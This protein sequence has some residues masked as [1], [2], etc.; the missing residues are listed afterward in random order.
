[1]SAVYLPRPAWTDTARGGALLTDT[2]LVGNAIHYPGRLADYG[3]LTQAQ[4]AAVLRGIWDWSVNHKGYSDIDYQVCITQSG[5]VW[6][7]RGI[8][9]VPAAHGS[10][11]NP[12]ANWE[13]GACLVMIGNDE[14]PTAELI[15]AYRHFRHT[16]WLARWPRATRLTDHSGV[17]G[18]LTSCAGPHI[19]ALIADGSLAQQPEEDDMPT[20]DEIAT[21]V[22]T[23]ENPHLRRS[24]GQMARYTF[25]AIRPEYQQTEGAV[26]G[27]RRDLARLEEL[28]EA[29][30]AAHS[31]GGHEEILARVDA[32][33]AERMAALAE[34]EARLDPTTLGPALAA[35]LSDVPAEQV[36]AALTAALRERDLRAAG[37]QDDGGT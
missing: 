3:R 34:L 30:L 7:L 19:R 37:D 29:S 36:T 13:Y 22:W 8:S 18:A 17:P 6:D 31:G 15:E 33:H 16:V 21:A 10:A 1:M 11:A 23:K 25:N 24:Y 5:R 28:A 27:F 2:R 32:H 4:E 35:H 12:D 14:K 20:A 26:L 9:R